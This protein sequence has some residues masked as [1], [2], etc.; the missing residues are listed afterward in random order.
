VID[1]FQ[2]ALYVNHD[3]VYVH[4]DVRAEDPAFPGKR[5]L[6]VYET[7]GEGV[8]PGR[9]PATPFDRY[10]FESVSFEAIFRLLSPYKD[11]LGLALYFELRLGD[12]EKELEWS[13]TPKELVRAPA[14]LGAEVN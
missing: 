13:Y 14:R 7:G 9:N 4:S 12:D 10:H 2:I 1:N 5:L 8:H 6:D 11:P 3:Y